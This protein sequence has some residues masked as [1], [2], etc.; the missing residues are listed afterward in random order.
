MEEREPESQAE[1]E[2]LKF[3]GLVTSGVTH[4]VKN[5]LSLINEYNGLVGD[6]ILAHEKGRPLNLERIKSLVGEVKR[7]VAAGGRVLGSLN[8]FAHSVDE[9]WQETELC[10]MLEVFAHLGMRRASLRKTTL[11]MQLPE[12]PLTL[13]SS[14]FLLLQAM[15][16]GLDAL[17]AQTPPEARLLLAGRDTGQGLSLTLA[18]EG[19]AG[20]RPPERIISPYLLARLGAR[21]LPTAQGWDLLLPL[22]PPESAADKGSI[23]MVDDR[24]DF[25][26][27]ISERMSGRGYR[28]ATVQSGEAA[29]AE[30]GRQSFDVVILD[31][32]MPGMDGLQT[33][34]E[35]LKLDPD[36]AVI[37]LTGYASSSELTQAL[38]LGAHDF[39]VKPADL[40]SLLA[41]VDQAVESRR[42]ARQP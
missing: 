23:L 35:L 9:P 14:P 7:Q 2:G 25:L 17:L 30:V 12:T 13:R 32:V 4:E 27:V 3:F 38:A 15:H 19:E 36:L 34:K 39:L 11:D 21:C 18:L 41:R 24:A 6:L 16:Q 29:L 28:V 33:L 5:C 37:V 20:W 8:R 22:A 26:Q 42:A 31:M 40:E 1:A 10:S